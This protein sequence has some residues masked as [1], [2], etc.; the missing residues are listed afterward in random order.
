MTETKVP[1]EMYF[2][3]GELR[4]LSDWVPTALGMKLLDIATRWEQ[5]LNTLSLEEE[6][7]TGNRH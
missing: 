1:I 2:T 4:A 5:F 3:V 6:D 7:E